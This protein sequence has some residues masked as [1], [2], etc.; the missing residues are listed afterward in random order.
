MTTKSQTGEPVLDPITGRPCLDAV[1]KRPYIYGDD[2]KPVVAPVTVPSGAERLDRLEDAIVALALY[3][4]ENAPIRFARSLA[5]AD[6]GA[7]I[8]RFLEVVKAERAA[9]LTV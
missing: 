6:A 7:S 4:V 2:G 8:L 3:S 5:A 1:T 9:A